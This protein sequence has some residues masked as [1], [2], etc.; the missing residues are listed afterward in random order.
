MKGVTPLNYRLL[1][2]AALGHLVIDIHQG[3]L[4]VLLPILR[5]RSELSYA[6]VTSLV[7]IMQVSS[8][9]IQP[10]VGFLSD[11]FTFRWL[12]PVSVLL[13][14]AGYLFLLGGT[15]SLAAFGILLSGI[16]VAGFHPD[17]SKLAHFA[18]DE[19][20]AWALSIF[21]LGG[22][23]GMAIGPM[24]MT[25]LLLRFGLPGVARLLWLTVPIA[26]VYLYQSRSLYAGIEA[27]AAQRA[28]AKPF[29]WRLSVLAPLGLLMTAI[30]LRAW[31][32]TATMSFIPLYFTSHLGES[33]Q[34]SSALLTTYIVAGALNS[35]LVGLSAE[36]WGIPATFIGTLFLGTI[37]LFI[38]PKVSGPWAFPVAAL[39]GGM[40]LSTLGI[41]T[42][43]GQQML[44]DHV[45]L[46]S[47]LVL[48]VTVGTGGI[49]AVLLGH[50]ADI[51]G[52]ETA[53]SGLPLFSLLAA[54]LAV[55]MVVVGKRLARQE[56]GRGE[57]LPA[58]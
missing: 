14:S 8:S 23:V 12:V 17:G 57:A 47:G 6:L 48:G 2:A 19:R 52:I 26:F 33:T 30:V 36:R 16:G 3:A 15:Y 13:A 51:K 9:V 20:K 29:P 42:A 45:G 24:V 41:T 34:F 50:V 18:S 32:H 44:P 43:L 38:L 31:A 49:G 53:M 56:E 22:S 39:A 1:A 58:A 40:L 28:E 4:P 55:T 5:E 10:T 11:R 35:L 37:V 25:F 27:R 7:L 46:A 54:C 21:S